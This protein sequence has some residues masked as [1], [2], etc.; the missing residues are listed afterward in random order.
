MAKCGR[1]VPI[2]I[3]PDCQEPM[4][5][6]VKMRTEVGVPE[7]NTG[8]LY[9]PAHGKQFYRYLADTKSHS[10]VCRLHEAESPYINKATR[11]CSYHMPS[12]QQI[13]FIS[14]VYTLS[15]L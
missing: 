10:Q 11:I 9:R 3:L 1:R 2:L 7:T 12:I 13:Y 8:L 4:K 6:L 14:S 5:L 15:P